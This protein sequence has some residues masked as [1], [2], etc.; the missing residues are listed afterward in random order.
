MPHDPPSPAVTAPSRHV[1]GPGTTR[2]LAVEMALSGLTGPALIVADDAAVAGLAPAWAAAFADAEWVHR[3]LVFGGTASRREV[4]AIAAEAGS[5]GATVIVGAGSQAVI[6]AALA[7]AAARALPA[8][9][10]PTD[11]SGIAATANTTTTAG[12]S[13]ASCPRL[14]LVDT[15]VSGTRPSGSSHG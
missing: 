6:D 10:C 2:R 4:D 8:V 15:E 11:M 7:A 9:A 3:V 14:V 5:L 13:P 12:A 1:E